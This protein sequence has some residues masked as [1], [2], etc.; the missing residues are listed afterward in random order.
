MKT[1]HPALLSACLLASSG[2]AQPDSNWPSYGLDHT[3][4][5]FSPLA[6]INR[7]NVSEL[8]LDWALDVPDAVS[9][10][11]TPLF[12]D[13]RLYFSADRAIVHAVD[14]ETGSLIWSYDPQAWKHAPRSIAIGFNTN[15]GIAHWR[16]RIFVGTGDGR[17]LPEL[18][19]SSWVSR[20][21]KPSSFRC[22]ATRPMAM[23]STSMLGW[24]TSP[25]NPR[26]SS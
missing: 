19:A 18:S 8:G 26:I 4:Q 17:C 6:Q 25:S 15:R 1:W 13:G 12:I 14:A 16:G 5:R 24:G 21:V 20:R 22:A 7:G 10:N 11:S 2:Q 3:E 9:L 23:G